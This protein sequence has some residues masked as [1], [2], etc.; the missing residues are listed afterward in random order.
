[1]K[2]GTQQHC[3]IGVCQEIKKEIE[4]LFCDGK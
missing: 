4:L 1:M 3:E 2:H